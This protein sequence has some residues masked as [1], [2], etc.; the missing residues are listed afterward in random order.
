MDPLTRLAYSC[1]DIFFSLLMDLP[2]S[3]VINVARG[4]R[5][6]HTRVLQ[7]PSGQFLTLWNRHVSRHPPLC[8]W[9]ELPGQYETLRHLLT[10]NKSDESILIFAVTQRYEIMV[11][12]LL[13]IHKRE[14]IFRSL[15]ITA[16]YFEAIKRGYVDFVDIFR[17]SDSIS[18]W[19][20][21]HLLTRSL[22]Y[23]QVEV[24]KY[25][26]DQEVD[27]CTGEYRYF[28]R[29][30]ERNHPLCV[31]VMLERVS[32]PHHIIDEAILDA[33][34]RKYHQMIT[35]LRSYRGVSQ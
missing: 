19:F 15:D 31:Q 22:W 24:V 7:S 16:A 14:T 10:V 30:V 13:D 35:L 23:G 28:L 8:K 12:A 2:V 17:R 4:N 26:L 25:A 32:I 5:T 3:S 20:A 9:S 11:R 1:S 33:T 18:S 29:A 34:K 21:D 27:L 6:L